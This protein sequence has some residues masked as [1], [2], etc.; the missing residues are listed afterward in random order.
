MYSVTVKLNST[1]NY[2]NAWFSVNRLSLHI[3]KTNIV[4]FTENHLQNNLFQITYQT[5]MMKEATNIKFLGLEL[6]RCVNQKHHIE[7]ILPKMSSACYAVRST[8]HFSSVT[9]LKMIYF[10]DFL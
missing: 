9:M 7:K 10:A 1:P 2:M 5:K 4:K 6:D 8:Y 3:E